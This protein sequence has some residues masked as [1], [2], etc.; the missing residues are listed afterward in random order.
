MSKN[1]AI[2]ICGVTNV[3]NVLDIIEFEEIK[4]IGSINFKDSK[5]YISLEKIADI[6]KQAKQKRSD[7]T[8][9]LL[10]VNENLEY[11]KKAMKIT[12]ADIL[13]LSGDESSELVN[14][15]DLYTIWKTIHV[16]N[17][18]DLEKMSKYLYVDKFILDT[19]VK[20][21]YGGTGE[22]FDLNIFNEAKNYTKN[23]VLAG[24]LNSQSIV[25]AVYVAKPD[26]VDISS[27][28]ESEIGVKDIQKVEEIIELIKGSQ[29]L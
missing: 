18:Q 1:T 17:L 15:I 9:V 13:Q 5:R 28:V 24:G 21:L 2:K 16:K 6:F 27:G 29:E 11:I 26:I 19:K 10:L 14:Q 7:I 3:E 12:G 25:N 22:T 8:C 4:Y 23:L 20:D